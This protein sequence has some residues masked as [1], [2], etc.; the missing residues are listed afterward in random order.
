MKQKLNKLASIG[1]ALLCGSAIA[2]LVHPFGNVRIVA[3]SAPLLD[4]AEVPSPVMGIVSRSCQNCHSEKTEWPFYSR[5]APMSWM[6]E[7]DVSEARNHMNLSQWNE[8][9]TD[10]RQELLSKIGSNVRNHRMPLPRYLLLHPEA[11][12]SD[13]EADQIY[14]W[15]RS[16]RRRLKA[17]ASPSVRLDVSPTDR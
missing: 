3:A 1:F 2:S 10:R 12:L 4:G 6:I 17:E 11:R 15:T 9:D 7:K 13:A 16:E 5:F 8:Y 14:Q